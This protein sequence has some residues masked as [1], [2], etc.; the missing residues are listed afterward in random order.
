MSTNIKAKLFAALEKLGKQNGHSAPTSQD[1]AVGKLHEYYVSSH[2]EAYFKKRREL[3]K[4][5]LDK[6]LTQIQQKKIMDTV[7]SV[8]RTE[9]ADTCTIIETDPYIFSVDVKNGASFLDTGALK[10]A[11]MRD[12]KMN[13]TEVEALIEK[14]TSR[15]DPSQSWKVTER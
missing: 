9:V 14:C 3:A 6:F 11:L 12:H 4:K 13:A 7:V 15:R 2:G 1:M 8:K 5:E 10:V